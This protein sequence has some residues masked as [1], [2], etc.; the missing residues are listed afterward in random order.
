MTVT[1]SWFTACPSAGDALTLKFPSPPKLA[2]TECAPSAS[3]AVLKVAT[4]D[5]SSVPVPRT[6]EPSAKVTVP[7][8]TPAP[9]PSRATVAVSVTASPMTAGDA[10]DTTTLVE[11]ARLTTC[12][13]AG[14]ALV[15]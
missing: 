10:D 3:A 14:E 8:G 15:S 6:A 9:A 5:A 13:S 7:V 11:F 12:D 4:P 2:V 1:P